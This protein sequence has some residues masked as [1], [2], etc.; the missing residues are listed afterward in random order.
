MKKLLITGGAGYIASHTNIECL[1]S[2]FELVIVDNFCNSSIEAVKRVEKLAGKKV[3]FYEADIRDQ[4]ALEEV[5]KKESDIEGVIHFAALKAV[6]ESVQKPLEY[7]EN[8]IS[9]SLVLYKVMRKYGVKNIVFS[10]SATVYGDPEK[11]PVDETA[12]IGATNPYGH[13]KVMME[14][15]LMDAAKAENWNVVILRYFNPVG[16]HD[17]GTIGED[18]EY[19]NNLLPFISQVAAGIREKV[20]VFGNDWPTP[21]GTGVRDYIHVVDLATAHV[22]ALQYIDKNP[23]VHVLNVG[24]G[25]G[26]SVLDMIKAFEKVCGHKIPYEIGPRR[27]GDVAEVLADPSLAVKELGWKAMYGLD[28]MVSSAW[29]WQ[30]MNPKGYRG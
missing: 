2:G 6:G 28:D 13:T 26:Y 23:G 9:G 21:D 14:Q 5:F 30:S 1:A 12:R 7:Y 27:D 29:K 25:Q 16:A 10:S 22:K 3:T 24:T 17:S 18:P 4:D 15:I 11:I 20:V 19:P 8:N